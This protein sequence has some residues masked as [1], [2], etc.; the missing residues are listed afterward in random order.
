MSSV[1]RT[2]PTTTLSHINT[3]PA[4]TWN[5]L[6]VNDI[7]LSVCVPRPAGDVY[8]RLPHTFTDIEC[9][10]GKDAV[11]WVESVAG[12]ASFTEVKAGIKK[13]DPIVL[14]AHDTDHIDSG[15]LVRE[16]ATATVVILACDAVEEDETIASPSTLKATDSSNH[17]HNVSPTVEDDTRNTHAPH[18]D[19]ATLVR[20]IAERGAQVTIIE[21][22]ANRKPR[23]HLGGIGIVAADNACITLHQYAFGCGTCAL[24]INTE[25]LGTASRLTHTM[26]YLVDGMSTLDVNHV[27]RQRG[28]DTLAEVTSSGVLF[29]GATKTMRETIDLVRGAKGASGSELETVLL[30]G[31]HIIN[32]TLPT[33][34][35]DEEDVAGNHG[36]SIGSIGSEQRAYLSARG[37]ND[38]EIDTLFV[39]AL[40]DDAYLHANVD[41]ARKTVLARAEDILALSSVEDIA[42]IAN[43]VTGSLSSTTRA[44]APVASEE[45]SSNDHASIY[46]EG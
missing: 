20:I 41:A 40:F 35:C 16:D 21:L 14:I 26:R 24:G 22:V 43:E 3:P 4:E 18:S 17:D 39:Q 42:A 36:A 19:S 37:L 10:V 32:K 44:D 27:V 6:H 9:G 13:S 12:D 1:D 5:Y 23:T 45:A 15:V 30:A 2:L 11:R 31:E 7:A 8:S 34:L 28:R 33:I 38:A 46:G 29:D 25:L